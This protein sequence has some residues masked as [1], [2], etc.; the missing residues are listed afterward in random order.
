M[1]N[2]YRK[3]PVVVKASLLTKE[4]VED[5]RKWV[6]TETISAVTMNDFG[7]IVPCLYIKTME[8]WITAQDG[9]YIIQGVAGEFY[10]C[11]PDIFKETY[12]S[13]E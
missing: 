1:V 10:P 3:K 7:D 5:I 2:L 4:T 6:T 12:E 9:D 13:V 11:K 8:G